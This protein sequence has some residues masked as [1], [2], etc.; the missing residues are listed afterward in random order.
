MR[1]AARDEVVGRAMMLN[2]RLQR[3]GPGRRHFVKVWR[4]FTTDPLCYLTEMV[5][6]YGDVVQLQIGPASRLLVSD[7]EMIEEVLLK[8]HTSFIKDDVTRRLSI[9]LGEG[10]LISEGEVWKRSRRRVAPK[11]RKKQIASYAEAMVR[12]ASSKASRYQDGE[13]YDIY[14]DM[15]VLTLDIVAET[16]FGSVV[17]GDAQLVGEAVEELMKLFMSHERSL[18]RLLPEWVPSPGRERARKSLEELDA[19][20]FRLIADRHEREAGDDLLWLLLNAE[21]DN[22]ERMNAR[23]LRDEM[24]TLFLAGHETTALALSYALMHISEHATVEAHLSRELE[25]VLGGRAPTADDVTNLPYTTAV[26][27]EAM[28]LHPP[29]WAIG[30]MAVRDVEIKGHNISKG[31]QVLMSQWVVHRDPQWWDAPEAFRPSRWLEDTERPRF[32]YFPFGG[33]PRLCV[34]N[35][36]AMMEMVLILATLVQR[37]S[38]RRCS[39]DNIGLVPAVTLRPEGEIWMRAST[40]GETCPQEVNP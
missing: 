40:R 36:F 32:A 26:I 39:F 23:E 24:L 19:L 37:V 33:G 31:E 6:A 35:H 28:R 30:R 34:G 17:E 14:H 18:M 25:S 1:A 29:A 7:P 12:H 22:G 15:M 3:P 2:E 9:A 16:L 4:D 10:L 11:L 20:M 5:R 38:F 21:D 13:A 8:Q 27:K